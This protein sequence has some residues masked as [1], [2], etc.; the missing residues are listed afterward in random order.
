[1][2]FEQEGRPMGS[3]SFKSR[4][5]DSERVRGKA[6]IPR[7]V[8]CAAILLLFIGLG[9]V[10]L[11]PVRTDNFPAHIK[12][13]MAFRSGVHDAADKY[14]ESW[15]KASPDSAA[16]HLLKGRIAVAKNQLPEAAEE[17]KRLQS[18]GAPRDEI[19][20]LHALIAAKAGRTTEAIPTLKQAFDE[21]GRKPDMQIDELLAKAY[22]ETFDLKNAGAVL[23]R[24]A[25]D[26]P[27]DPK[28]HLWRAE[29]HG[30]D[31]GQVGAV[32]Q[33]YRE[34]LRRDPSL[35]K[36]RLGLA[37]ELRKAHRTAEAAAEYDAYLA[38]EPNNAAAHLGA[39]RNLLEHG[40]QA[41]ASRHLDR[42][43]ELD[44]KNAEPHIELANAASRRGD[45]AATLT[46]IDR[47]IALDPHDIGARHL[48][49]LALSRL[50][51]GDEA[52]AEQATATRL[53]ADLKRLN[54]AR[55][56]LIAQPHDRTS[57]LEIARWMFDH[58]H[59]EEGARWAKQILSEHR[60]DP[61]A[62]R[63]LV[64]YHRRRG[65]AG[66]ANFYSLMVPSEKP[67]T[68]QKRPGG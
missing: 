64:D 46:S 47:A 50:G 61:D 32:E 65:E 7:R 5:Q 25:A 23:D 18:L 45:W 20:L 48:R 3:T 4:T 12:A 54:E 9:V 19:R 14:L 24:W 30:R 44:P 55:T 10:V 42:A 67:L 29:I 27:D 62:A 38:L 68:Q 37:E 26:F 43:I 39:G 35:A 28:P 58:A 6:R 33:D 63:L 60:D 34:A 15:L 17:L 11:V 21:A 2:G 40:D 56:R 13:Q 52:K 22:L 49:G 31:G 41:A 51:R 66:L 53:R 36:A 59:D 8:T 57:Q 1:M 16:A